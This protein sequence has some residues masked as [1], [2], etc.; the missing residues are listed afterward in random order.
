MCKALDMSCSG[1]ARAPETWG[2]DQTPHSRDSLQVNST[3][4]NPDKR[5]A[6]LSPL[7]P[8]LSFLSLAWIL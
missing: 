6:R 8:N 3:L 1:A 7:S 4:H 2:P 5:F